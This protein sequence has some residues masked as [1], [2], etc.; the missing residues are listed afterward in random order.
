MPDAVGDISYDD[1]MDPLALAQLAD[2]TALYA[3]KIENLIKK[4]IKIFQY[5][6]EKHQVPNISKTLYCHFAANPVQDPLVIDENTII[7]SVDPLKGYRYLGIFFYPTNEIMVIIELQ[8]P[9]T[10]TNV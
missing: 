1:F 4:F 2:D 8:Q 9:S 7:H 3:E 10:S 5:S 6:S